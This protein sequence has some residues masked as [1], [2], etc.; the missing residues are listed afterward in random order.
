MIRLRWSLVPLLVAPALAAQS[1]I[2]TLHPDE[3]G[4]NDSFG[5]AM[6][7]EDPYLFVGDRGERAVYVYTVPGL[8]LHAKWTSSDGQPSDRFGEDVEAADG[9]L[10]IGASGASFPFG[11][12]YVFDIATG[13]ELIKLETQDPNAL[14]MGEDV[15]IDG[16][17]AILGCPLDKELG[18]GGGAAY[19]FDVTTGAQVFKLRGNDTVNGDMFGCSVAIDGNRALVGASTA[20]SNFEGAA[21]LFDLTT[22]QQLQKWSAGFQEFLGHRVELVGTTGVIGGQAI[23]GIGALRI[24]DVVSGAVQFD[25]FGSMTNS[26]CDHFPDGI[27][28]ENGLM[29]V[30][31]TDADIAI[32]G[33]ITGAAW[34]FDLATGQELDLFLPEAPMKSDL[35]GRGVA[36]AGGRVLVGAPDA[37]EAVTDGG[38]VYQFGPDP[39]T[40]CTAKTNSLG[41]VPAI[42]AVGI[43]SATSTPFD[44]TAANVLNNKNG[45]L[46]Y[47]YNGPTNTPFLGGT[48]CVAPPLRRTTVQNSGGNPPPNDCSGSYVLDVVAVAPERRGPDARPRGHRQRAVVVAR[49]ADSGRYRS[50]AQRR[51]RVR[52]RTLTSPVHPCAL[53]ALG[54]AAPSQRPWLGAASLPL[55]DSAWFFRNGVPWASP[56]PREGRA[57]KTSAVATSRGKGRIG[58]PRDVEQE[59][60]RLRG[61]VW[62][63]GVV[64]E[65]T[66][67]LSERDRGEGPRRVRRG[68]RRPRSRRSGV[69]RPEQRRLSGPVP[70]QGR[71]ERALL[72]QAR[73]ERRAAVR[74]RSGG[75]RRRR[76]RSGDGR[77]RGRLRQRRRPGPVHHQLGSRERAVE[78]HLGRESDGRSGGCSSRRSRT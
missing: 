1:T 72:E 18:V 29:L 44:I 43:P 37:D 42:A 3:I 77:S 74:A 63:A 9:R 57:T 51:V 61:A 39:T 75:D 76:R 5:E 38:C 49:S 25:V 10:V 50:R 28:I 78:E 40:Y 21:Y 60:R 34:L 8:A 71:A 69:R 17:L 4:P 62:S 35:F 47:G 45:L 15:D 6:E 7:F 16:N 59:S 20:G 58:E 48:L 22:G 55:L 46:F 65:W 56:K 70:A 14:F 64:S 54:V 12:A 11:A 13:Q 2:Y 32:P 31:G 67:R 41:C 23:G 73:P 24:V 30:G 26:P 66:G 53:A 33:T 27:D 36:L 52:A 68:L 19:V